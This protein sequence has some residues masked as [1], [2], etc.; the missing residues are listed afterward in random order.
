MSLLDWDYLTDAAHKA[1]LKNTNWNLSFKMLVPVHSVQ[2]NQKLME[3]RQKPN[4][5]KY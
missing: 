3:G 1:S 2:Q 4:T 5:D